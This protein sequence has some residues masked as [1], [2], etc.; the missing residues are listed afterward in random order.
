MMMKQISIGTEGNLDEELL[1]EGP[2]ATNMVINDF[3]DCANPLV[4]NKG[5]TRMSFHKSFE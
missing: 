4:L 1:D 5:K 2:T 3:V